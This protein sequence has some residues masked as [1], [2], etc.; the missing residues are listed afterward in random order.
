MR[1]RR[2]AMNRESIS[3]LMGDEPFRLMAAGGRDVER[4]RATFTGCEVRTNAVS[5]AGQIYKDLLHR[6]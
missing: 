6:T 2:L 4:L 1:P 3:R 5:I